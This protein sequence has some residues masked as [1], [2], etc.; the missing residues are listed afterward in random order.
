MSNLRQKLNDKPWIGWTVAG[1]M[2]VLAGVVYFTRSSGS[3]VEYS[4]EYM[5]EMVTVKF[6]DTGDE[7]ELPRGRFERMLR[8][9]GSGTLDPSKGLINPKTNQPTGFLFDKSDWEK[10]VQRINSERKELGTDA[11]ASKPEQGSTQPPGQASTPA[12]SPQ[13]K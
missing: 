12:A 1:A 7:L 6:A 2:A 9:S 13:P 4:Q 11:A 8:S 5:T 10:T 3:N